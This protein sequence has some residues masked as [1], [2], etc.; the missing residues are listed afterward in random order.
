MLELIVFAVAAATRLSIVLTSTGGLGGNF[1]YDASVYY[2]AADSFTFGRLPYRDFVLLHPPGIMLALAP[3]AWI[4]RLTS[5]HAGFMTGAVAFSLLGAV[6]A[7]LIVRI[8]RRIGLPGPAALIGGLFYA[9]WMGA[10][11][12]EIVGR[13]EPLGAFLFLCGLL[14]TVSAHDSGRRRT[15]LL[16]GLALGAAVGVKIWWIVPALVVLAWHLTRQRRAQLPAM[17]LG[18]GVSLALIYGP[19][20]L[21]APST[22]WHMVVTEQ[23]GRPSRVTSLP[24]RLYELTWMSGAGKLSV[25]QAHA[26]GAV[27]GVLALIAVA[28]AWR[29]RPAR[30]FVVLAACQTLL[31]L[32]APSW[33]PFYADYL[34]PTAALCLAAA[35]GPSGSRE[36]RWVRPLA[37]AVPG[38]CTVI[39]AA[40][41]LTYLADGKV[42]AVWPAPATSLAA[43]ASQVHCVMSN[44]PMG[45][46]LIDS[47]SRDLGDGCPNWVDVSG[48]EF[49]IG[50]GP[51]SHGASHLTWD[52][53][54]PVLRKYLFS[55]Q[56]VVLVTRSGSL[57]DYQTRTE[58]ARSGILARSGGG[59]LYRTPAGASSTLQQ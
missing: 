13:L 34:A 32:R 24:V 57:L 14:A 19:F 48:R 37:M 44:S 21:A 56:A 43:D 38:L 45:L 7:A 11:A 30:L 25:T 8:A 9:L 12:V 51:S 15:Y 20:F 5:D 22:M 4:G 40:S 59:V 31:L 49:G 10:A 50:P 52:Q 3:F 39:V 54:Q 55:G 46:I 29:V 41:T 6:N 1:G 26:L 36:R 17:A 27:L 53:W 47:L 58:L 23:L 28:L 42:G 18:G 33:F 2:A 35:V 16:A